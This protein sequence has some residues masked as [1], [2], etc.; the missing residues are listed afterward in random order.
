MLIDLGCTLLHQCKRHA[1]AEASS[2]RLARTIAGFLKQLARGLRG[3][4]LSEQM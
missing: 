1:G 4:D 3:R 2:S